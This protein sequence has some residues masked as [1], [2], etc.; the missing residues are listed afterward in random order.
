[1]RLTYPS[2]FIA[3]ATLA[4]VGYLAQGAPINPLVVLIG[5]FGGMVAL[6]LDRIRILG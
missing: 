5:G 3:F 2:M 6:W 4:V 1:M